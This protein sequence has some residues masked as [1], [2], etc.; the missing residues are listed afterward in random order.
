MKRVRFG[1]VLLALI[2]AGAANAAERAFGVHLV[3]PAEHVEVLAGSTVPIGWEA[4][5]VPAGIEEWEAFV[6]IDGGKTYPVRITPHLDAGIH[7]FNWIVPSL[8]GADL[9]ILLRFGD[10]QEE[11][12]FPFARRVRISGTI[13]GETSRARFLQRGAE[14]DHGRVLTEWVEGSREGSG[15]YQVAVDSRWL[16]SDSEWNEG[17]DRDT[18]QAVGISSQ[19]VEDAVGVSH[20]HADGVAGSRHKERRTLRLRVAGV[21]LLTGRLNI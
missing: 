10:E 9:S 8:P 15:V 13:T 17:T 20:A 1:C 2:S 19:R 5:N 18:T 12:E 11:V 4:A 14:D 6:S 21:L 7:R 16:V 3:E